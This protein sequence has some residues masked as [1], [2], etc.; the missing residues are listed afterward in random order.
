MQ[1]TY[2]IIHCLDTQP[3]TRVTKEMLEHW[4]MAPK[5]LFNGRVKY[6]GKVYPS[7]EALPDNEIGGVSIRNL[8]GRGWDRLGYS[9]MFHRDGEKEIVTPYDDNDNVDTREVTWGCTG[10]NLAS[11]HIAL[12]GGYKCKATDQFMDHFTK[13]QYAALHR[14][15]TEELEKHPRVKVGGHNDFATRECPGFKVVDLLKDYKLESHAV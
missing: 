1:L 13:Q 15:L 5:D 14:Y 8:T 12:E 7:R 2:F 4:H 11:R 10:Y 6:L 9:V 3:K